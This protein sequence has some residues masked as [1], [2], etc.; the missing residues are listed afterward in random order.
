MED[1]IQRVDPVTILIENITK[2]ITNVS[3]EYEIT[4]A[5]IVGALEFVKSNLITGDFGEDDDLED[6]FDDD[7]DDEGEE[8]KKDLDDD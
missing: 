5:T 8:W 7:E 4:L 6:L 2:E 3:R 1:E